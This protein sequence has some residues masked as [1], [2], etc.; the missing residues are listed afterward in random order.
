[1]ILPSSALECPAT[2]DAFYCIYVEADA[3][4]IDCRVNG[5]TTIAFPIIG[6]GVV[7]KGLVS[8]VSCMP[9]NA[10][11]CRTFIYGESNGT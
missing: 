3:D 5:T 9:A 2:A 7:V 4:I 6:I 8:S 11:I 10:L 1:L